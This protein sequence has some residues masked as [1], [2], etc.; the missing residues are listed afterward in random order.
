MESLKTVEIGSPVAVKINDEWLRGEVIM[1][2]DDLYDVKLVD[3]NVL[4]TVE[5]ESLFLLDLKFFFSSRKALKCS[6]AGIIPYP[7]D[8]LWSWKAIMEFKAIADSDKI[9]AVFKSIEDDSY[10]VD[11]I[12]MDEMCRDL[13]VAGQLIM[14]NVATFKE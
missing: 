12:V 1:K 9:K 7:Y 8:K 5:I 10:K 2:L 6:L 14:K 13:N 3:V 4:K 11:L